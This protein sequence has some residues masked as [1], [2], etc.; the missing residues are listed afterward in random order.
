MSLYVGTSGWSYKEWKDGFYPADLPQ[1]LFLEYYGQHLS[2]CEVNATFYRLQSD[3]TFEKWSE[4]VPAEFRFASKAHRG[5]TH[6]KDFAP[7]SERGQFLQ[8]YIDSLSP[9]GSKLACV[10]FQFPPFVKRD[11]DA[12]DGLL[13]AIAGELRFACEFRDESWEDDAVT[14]RVAEAGGTICV[15]ETEGEVPEALPAGPLAYIRIRGQKYSPAARKRWLELLGSEGAK[16]D[17]F[18]FAKHEGI[19]AG[20]PYGGVGLAQWLFEN[21]R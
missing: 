10:L 7:D 17:V 13:G 14:A 3:S 1:S 5:I 8:T 12:L 15:S 21:S 18:A 16:R 6:R 4:S 19:P 11:D 20:D 9:L 2:A